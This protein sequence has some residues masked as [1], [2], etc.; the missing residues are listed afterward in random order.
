MFRA[1]DLGFRF[2]GLGLTLNYVPGLS[3]PYPYEPWSKLLV[4]AL[5]TSIVVPYIHPY[6]IPLKE[7]RLQL[8]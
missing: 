4:S 3:G 2:C 7:F 6:I 5:I 8:T 1:S